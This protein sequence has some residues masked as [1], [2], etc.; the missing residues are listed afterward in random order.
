[1]T[2]TPYES[3]G[4]ISTE[5][6][7]IQKE[8]LMEMEKQFAGKEIETC[9]IY[10]DNG[11]AYTYEQHKG[12]LTTP[13]KIN[14][15]TKSVLSILIGKALEENYL[16][17]LD[18][19][20]GDILS[21]NGET[22]ETVL[23]MS[24]EQLLTMTSGFDLKSWKEI[25]Q[26]PDWI[27]A[28]MS[29]PPA[30][31]PGKKMTYNNSDSHLLSAVVQKVTGMKTKEFAARYLFEPL[32]IQDYEWEDDPD[33]V[34][35]GGYGL[36]LTPVDLLKYAVMILQNG[37]W[38]GKEVIGAD[39]INQA[40]KKHTKTDKFK[41]YY[42]YH[43]WVSEGSNGKHPALYYAAGRGGKF[44]FIVPEQNLAAVFTA[45]LTVKESLLP[46]QWFVRYIT[47]EIT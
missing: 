33:G 37:K 11:L 7:G 46:Y 20:I 25:S 32:Q 24:V 30:S 35:L 15:V 42:G 28:I 38:E 17:S 4:T 22:D 5:E 18:L 12:L 1:M 23:Q 16:S 6:A 47:G 39:W 40:L 29:K 3:F 27:H 21:S 14:S 43:W 9:L 31:S 10:K 44:I 19:S 41:Q 45:D 8:K 13:H 36:Y 26:S 34:S 2:G